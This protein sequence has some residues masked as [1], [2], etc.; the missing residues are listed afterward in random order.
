MV[1]PASTPVIHPA[2]DSWAAEH[3]ADSQTCPVC[4]AP[5]ANQAT[6]ENKGIMLADYVCGGV[7]PHIWSVRW[8][9]A[10]VSA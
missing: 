8:G 7:K 9:L 10:Q 2:T 4:F 3:I 1:E 6:R 5:V